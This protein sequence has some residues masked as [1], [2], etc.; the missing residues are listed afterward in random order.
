M[1]HDVPFGSGPMPLWLLATLVAATVVLVLLVCYSLKLG[2]AERAR[3]ALKNRAPLDLD[4][5]HWNAY[6]Q[7]GEP[8]TSNLPSRPSSR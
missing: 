5:E 1:Q 3:E 4:Q 8:P 2:K 7:H 6:Q